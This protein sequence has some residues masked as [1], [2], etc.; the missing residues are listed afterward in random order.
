MRRHKVVGAC[1][2]VRF[3]EFRRITFSLIPY[4]RAWGSAS[5]YVSLALVI[6]Y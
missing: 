4:C 2:E 1:V 6:L 5:L 3:P